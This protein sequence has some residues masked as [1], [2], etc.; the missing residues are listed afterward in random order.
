M[1]T[2]KYKIKEVHMSV[3]YLRSRKRRPVW[4]GPR[5]PM[6]D[7]QGQIPYG[8]CEKCGM[9]CYQRGQVL[10]P[11]C[12]GEENESEESLCKM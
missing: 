9:E 8:W 6:E 10:C 11:E 3:I 1:Y 7:T 12:K 4:I 5:R 2:S